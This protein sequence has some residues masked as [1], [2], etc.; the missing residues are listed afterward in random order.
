M[1]EAEKRK[2]RAARFAADEAK[3]PPPIPEKRMAW[4]GGKITSN[5][6]EATKKFLERKLAQEKEEKNEKEGKA[7]EDLWSREVYLGNLSYKTKPSSLKPL[8]ENCVSTRVVREKGKSKGYGFA[9]FESATE[10]LAALKLDGT[11]VDGRKLSVRPAKKKVDVV[12]VSSGGQ[13]KESP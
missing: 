8:F 11:T 5:K 3:G 13:A 2:L 10:A 9:T 7:E 4:P 1:D 6:E 12:V